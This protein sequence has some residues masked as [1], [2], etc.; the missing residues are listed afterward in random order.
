MPSILASATSARCPAN[1]SGVGKNLLGTSSPNFITFESLQNRKPHSNYKEGVCQ[2]EDG[3]VEWDL[4]EINHV[5]ISK[6]W[7][8]NQPV[9]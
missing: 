6:T 3:E 2:V 8:T 1:E 9:Y 4:D 5:S 7:L